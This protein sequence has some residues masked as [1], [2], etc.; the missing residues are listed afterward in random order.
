[1]TTSSGPV[2]PS[3]A[4]QANNSSPVEATELADATAPSH[5]G[6]ELD[7]GPGYAASGNRALARF[8]IGLVGWQPTCGLASGAAGSSKSGITSNSTPPAF[9]RGPS[10]DA[11]GAAATATRRKVTAA[12]E[13]HASSRGAPLHCICPHVEELAGLDWAATSSADK[14]PRQGLPWLAPGGRWIEFCFC[15]GSE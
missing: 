6:L 11:I 4:Q 13:H 10:L 15:H 7:T 5:Q 3:Q 1:M 9:V 8:E 12:F 14:G 2:G